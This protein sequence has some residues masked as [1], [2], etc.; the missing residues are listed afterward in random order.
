MKA[1]GIATALITATV[2]L[3][4]S[5]LASA[6]IK[7]ACDLLTKAEV[8]AAYGVPMNAPQKQIMGMC[9]FRST[10][11]SPFKQ[12]NMT[13]GQDDSREAWE[14]HEKEIDPDVKPI[15]VPG[16]GD[17][18]NLYLRVLDARLS[19]HKGKTTVNLMMNLGKMM[20]TAADA[21]PVAKQLGALAASRIP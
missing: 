3:A 6:Q 9:E 12:L 13:V 15:A 5:T 16:V 8:E 11:S 21:M 4:A 2:A 19:I 10:G 17:A 7:S 14:K 1:T 18:A 20:P